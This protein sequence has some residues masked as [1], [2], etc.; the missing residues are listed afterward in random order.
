MAFETDP[1]KPK[2]AQTLADIRAEFDGNPARYKT[3]PVEADGY[4]PTKTLTGLLGEMQFKANPAAAKKV[5]DP[6]KV[7]VQ[8]LLQAVAGGRAA[9]G[10]TSPLALIPED[11]LARVG[12]YIADQD[13]VTLT[14]TLDVW[15]AR[16]YINGDTKTAARALVTATVD[17][18]NHSA[19]VPTQPRVTELWGEGGISAAII[20][21]ALGR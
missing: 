2:Y 18:P 6:A 14:I 3:G 15:H 21:A 20:D 8:T 10:T 12:Q 13:I 4:L 9:D 17:D 11:S 1:A 5:P 16:G 7:N 19:Q